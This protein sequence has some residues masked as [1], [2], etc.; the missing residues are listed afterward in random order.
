MRGIVERRFAPTQRWFKVEAD[1][2]DMYVLRH[3]EAT[4][5]CEL[6]TYTRGA[7]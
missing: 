7:G 3:D 6:A 1:D 4:G 5:D 2:A